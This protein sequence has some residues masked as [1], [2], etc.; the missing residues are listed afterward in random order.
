[1]DCA[2]RGTKNVAG[3][4]KT[5]CLKRVIYISSM[6]V[7][8]CVNISDGEAISEESPLEKFPELR[9]AYSLAKRRAEDEAL[10][11]LGDI[12]PQWTILRPSVIVGDRHDL[13]SPVGLRLGELLL[14]PGSGTKTLRLVHVEDVATAIV[15]V[16]QNE[17]T[18]GC[19][20]NLSSEGITQKSYINQ[21]IRKAG[22]GKLRVI[23]IPLWMASSVAVVLRFLRLLSNKVPIISQRRLAS[24]YQSVR[25]NSDAIIHGTGWR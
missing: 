11:H 3:A 22:Y 6:S 14:C 15:K 2:I 12:L 20:Y 7:Y 23:Y 24:L 25:V 5:S 10:S 16:I 13:F 17:G 9:G 21:F 8:D 18:R 4:A 19:I 1:L